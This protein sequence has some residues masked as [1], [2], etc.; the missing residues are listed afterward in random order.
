M[1]TMPVYIHT[2]CG[3]ELYWRNNRDILQLCYVKGLI[4]DENPMKVTV[5]KVSCFVRWSMERLPLLWQRMI[6]R[7]FT[8]F[9][10]LLL[11]CISKS[12]WAWEYHQSKIYQGQPY[13]I[14]SQVHS[15]AFP[16]FGLGSQ[17]YWKRLNKRSNIPVPVC[18][19][20]NLKLALNIKA[21]GTQHTE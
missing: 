8:G 6:D 19:K 14:C 1:V 17:Q 10:Q 20:A 21:I 5:L 16:N 4:M 13:T 11:W 2:L 3:I 12:E 9:T 18:T 15:K 7:Y